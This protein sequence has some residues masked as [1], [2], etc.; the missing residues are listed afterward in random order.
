M[1]L[2]VNLAAPI[3]SSHSVTDCREAS[4]SLSPYWVIYNIHATISFLGRWVLYSFS[5]S[6]V[7]YSRQVFL[8]LFFVF[9]PT[10]ITSVGLCVLFDSYHQLQPSFS[11]FSWF[12]KLLL[13]LILL[14]PNPSFSLLSSFFFLTS[15]K[16]STNQR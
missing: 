9:L 2:V 15:P 7:L 6:L 4:L 12:H 1:E 14:T 13:H 3:A 5:L 16:E 10:L 11:L 8:H